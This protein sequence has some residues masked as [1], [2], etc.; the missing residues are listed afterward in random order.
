MGIG[1]RISSYNPMGADLLSIKISPLASCLP[2][3]ICKRINL[4]VYPWCSFLLSILSLFAFHA[5]TC[6]AQLFPVLKNQYRLGSEGNDLA[7]DLASDTQGHLYVLSTNSGK[8][9]QV[10]EHFGCTDIWVASLTQDARVR[11]EKTF[12]GMYCDEAG[13]LLVQGESVWVS[14]T[15]ASFLEHPETGDRF[16]AGDA[17]LLNLR[18][19][20]ALNYYKVF[21]AE[22]KELGAGLGLLPNG[23]ILQCGSSFS[24]LPFHGG[25]PGMSDIWLIKPDADTS[26]ALEGFNAGGTGYDWPVRIHPISATEFALTANTVPASSFE[27]GEVYPKPWVIVFDTALKKKRSFIPS[28]SLPV[29]I[30]ASEVNASGH[31]GLVGHS[32]RQDSDPQFW[33]MA[34]DLSGKVLHEK[35]WGGSGAE[36]LSAMAPCKDGG[37]ILTGWSAYY[38]LENPNIKGG[39]DLWVIRLNAQ[40]EV[41][42]ERTFGGPGEER[43]KAVIEYMP[44]VYYVL[45]QRNESPDTE[46]KDLWLLRI[47]EEECDLPELL[48]S[49][50]FQGT[51]PR[52]GQYLQFSLPTEEKLTCIWD[53]GDGTTSKELNPMKKYYRVGDYQVKVTYKGTQACDKRVKMPAPLMIR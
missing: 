35:I 4:S 34:C 28:A 53:F 32:I 24:A 22:E 31:L 19:E 38:N 23:N 44:G 42:W 46:V 47:E 37:W 2:K 8:G 25:K 26:R 43:G 40:Y 18:K 48:P 6:Q 41:E 16:R 14:G 5:H 3:R 7:I 33:F 21:G 36:Y 50:K 49:V 51:E 12:G 9:K 17:F 15:T 20:G 1:W 27:N 52:I 13:D 29:T 39:E 10:S 11:W 45:G 30:L